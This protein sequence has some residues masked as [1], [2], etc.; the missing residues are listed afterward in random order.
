MKKMGLLMSAFV[1]ISSSIGLYWMSGTSIHYE[2]LKD[3]AWLPLPLAAVFLIGF[4]RKS[5][6]IVVD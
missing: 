1:L 4:F 6:K 2:E 3:I 5:K